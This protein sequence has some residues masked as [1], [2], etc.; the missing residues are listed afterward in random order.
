MSGIGSS[1]SSIKLDY[2]LPKAESVA[3]GQ[4]KEEKKDPTSSVVLDAKIN[5]K[6]QASSNQATPRACSSF[7]PTGVDFKQPAKQISASEAGQIVK[8]ACSSEI[9]EAKNTLTKAAID[10]FGETG[11]TVIAGA[12]YLAR[13]RFSA[14]GDIAGV[15]T[16][17]DIDVR[18]K[19]IN[20]GARTRIGSF[21]L[22]SNIGK[23]NGTGTTAGVDVSTSTS[24]GGRLSAYLNS[25][26][27]GGQGAGIT[28][29]MP[30]K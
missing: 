26:S 9:S 10:T 6:S 25:T 29:T 11:S 20:L 23:G 4:Q 2:S 7:S 5:E 17:G 13:G 3:M 19:S 16:T 24:G 22:S 18:N 8:S 21:D 12:A 30:L 1:S 28:F 27:G 14:S 15:T